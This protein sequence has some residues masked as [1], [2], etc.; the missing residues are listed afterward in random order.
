MTPVDEVIFAFRKNV[1]VGASAGTGKTYRLT[2]LYALLTLG[3]TSMGEADDRTLH[4]PILPSRIVATTFSRAAAKE[5]RGR[6]EALLTALARGEETSLDPVI[7]ARLALAAA[8]PDPTEIARRARRAL[9]EW[10][11]SRVETLH[12]YAGE[13]LRGR[14]AELGLS[15]DARIES[16]DEG[17]E[18]VR[19]IVDEVLSEWLERGGEQQE[20]VRDVVRVARGL[21]NA[22]EKLRMLFERANEDGVDLGELRLAPHR[23]V[24]T[25]VLAEL[26]DVARRAAHPAIK[27]SLRS[28][29]MDLVRARSQ[30][31][32][33]DAFAEALEAFF[34]VS[35]SRREDALVEAEIAR[36][37]GPFGKQNLSRSRNFLTYVRS[38][39][40]LEHVESRILS[41][42]NEVSARTRVE[43]A[44]RGLMS[45]GDLLR[46]A[47]ALLAA[48]G[49]A[50]RAIR[51]EVDALLVDEF[52]D[53][54]IVQRDLVTLL[55]HDPAADRTGEHGD[56]RAIAPSGLFVVG[57][58][59]QSIYGFRGVD[60]AVFSEL[61]LA[62]G[63]VPAH[64]ALG[65]PPERALP[66]LADYV[67]LRESRRSARPIVDFVNA[68]SRRDFAAGNPESA[69]EVH[70]TDAEHLEI[71]ATEDARGEVTLLADGGSDLPGVDPSLVAGQPKLREAIVAAFAA[72]HL[73]ATRGLA[74]RDVAVLA[75][76]RRMISLLEF[77]FELLELPHVVAGRAL[78]GTRE[79]R[80]A[81]ALLRLLVDPR[82]RHALAIVLRGPI[83]SATDAGLLHLTTDAGLDTGLLSPSFS[84]AALDALGE[85]G[86]RIAAFRR[87]FLRHRPALLRLSPTRALSKA[88]E[89]FEMDRLLASL[90]RGNIRIGNLDRLVG[91][92]A[93]QGGT[94]FGFSRWLARQIDD[95][96]DEIEAAVFAPE[97]EA[98][99]VLTIHA[100]KGLDFEAVV[101]VD[102]DASA[103]MRFEPIA[104]DAGGRWEGG[105]AELASAGGGSASDP[106]RKDA[107]TLVLSH[108]GDIDATPAYEAFRAIASRR[109]AAERRRLTYVAITRAKRDLFLIGSVESA[110]KNTAAEL[111]ADELAAPLPL[112]RIDERALVVPAPSAV[113][114][115]PAEPVDP[116]DLARLPRVRRLPLAT[117]ALSIFRGCPRRYELRFMR[118]LAEPVPTGQLDLFAL[119]HTPELEP[120]PALPSDDED[121][122]RAASRGRAAHRVLEL[123]PL[124]RFGE[125]GAE[126]LLERAL[127]A[128][129]IAPGDVPAL[130]GKLARFVESP[131]ARTLA[132]AAL[133]EREGEL[134]V[135]VGDAPQIRLRGVFD[136]IVVGRD[137]IVDIV[138]YK[139]ARR[140]SD[141]SPY[142]FQLKTYA[143]A[144]S[145]RFPEH[146]VRASLVFLDDDPTPVPLSGRGPNGT[147]SSE[148]LATFG[149]EI[150]ALAAAFV[151]ARG[152]AHFSKVELPVCRENRCGFV[153]ACHAP[154]GARRGSSARS[155]QRP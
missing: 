56:L 47:R 99:R 102:L 87:D 25:R 90:P 60:V 133:V 116:P 1:I 106:P 26:D 20:A 23:E 151:V 38:A 81:S 94:L 18:L 34:A 121:A 139:L 28:A 82:D 71:G 12:G 3:L 78:Y 79:V 85:E 149:A 73:V 53:T 61:C 148:E 2:G 122:A 13:L 134:R 135:D 117:T 108:Q 64:E 124:E 84:R 110:H 115:A 132:G 7:A 105:P 55:R 31:T 141:L 83:V 39:E 75:R 69:F 147:F 29:A 93:E 74:L 50:A 155:E 63:G 138:D 137:G 62:L 128:E 41:I 114:A 92:A 40:A 59:K 45:F 96:T 15:H 32:E 37:K 142:A 66:P 46:H 17:K 101:V 16:E 144:A 65:A 120:D 152:T 136:L 24:A 22:R 33:G 125:R 8:P 89:I 86:D 76:S 127:L 146:H 21:P 123:F 58:R 49:P 68:F 129:G 70:Y 140:R 6:I 113:V 48:G 109:E 118:G 43:R 107:R 35:L 51:G 130:T 91:I 11:T 72:R 111:L 57:D 154:G 126:P 52:Q 88:L 112:T 145:R 4:P 104:Y 30:G 27:A 19:V 5:M 9:D 97:D 54:S 95:E 119:E 103:R 143:L 77:A 131:F 100:A 10:A 153:T 98:I 42:V 14:G 67:S 80:D 36:L 44:R 150:E